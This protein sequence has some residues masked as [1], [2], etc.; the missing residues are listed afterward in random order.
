MNM[1][2]FQSL[3]IGF[4]SGITQ[5]LPVSADA[6]RS[7]LNILCG[8]DPE[9]AV[10]RLLVHTAC[11]IAVYGFWGNDLRALRRTGQLMKVHPKRRR[12]PVEP[13]QANTLRLLRSASVVVVVCRI[14]TIGLQGIRGSLHLLPIG[15]VITGMLLMIPELVRNGN[16]DSRNMPRFNGILMGLGSGL[17]F[18]PGFS[19]I[20]CAMSL[21]QWQGVDRQFAFRFAGYLMIPGLGC[22]I[23]TD[24]LAIIGGGAAAFSAAGF[25]CA[26]VGAIASGIACRLGL[27]LIQ[28]LVKFASLSGF[29][30]YCWGTALVSMALYLFI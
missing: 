17:E 5:I 7:I 4:V 6:H 3:L 12:K 9:D 11:L 8:V 16:M 20:G 27:E 26:I 19:G 28:R 15:L 18:I 29:S 14:L 21:G 23:V 1:N 25:G 24:L 10:F 30:Y 2:F 13:A 22:Q